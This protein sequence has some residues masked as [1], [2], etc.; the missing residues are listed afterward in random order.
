MIRIFFGSPGC[1]KTTTAVRQMYLND[2]HNR[3]NHNYCNFSVDP[4]IGQ[5]FDLKGL[6]TWTFPEYSY[7]AIDEAGIEYN[8]RAYKSLDQ[9][10]IRWLKLHR[11]YK[12]DVDVF[13]QSWEDMDITI[14]RLADQLWYVKRVGPF[15]LCRKIR[16]FVMIKEEDKQ[17]IDGFE[18][19]PL[20]K[21][22]LPPPFHEKTWFF[23]NRRRYY[24]YFDTYETPPTPLHPSLSAKG[25]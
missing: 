13:S 18:F 14:R 8:S 17:I 23:V 5:K 4:F 3:Y 11:H 10:T 19:K 9:S 20:I 2:K 21:R 22:L 1:G 6:G 7:L 16:R 15:T 25:K 24:K 12:V